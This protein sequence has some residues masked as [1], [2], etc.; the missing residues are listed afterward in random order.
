MI[1]KDNIYVLQISLIS[2]SFICYTFYQHNNLLNEE[3]EV[4]KEENEVLKEE[5]EVFKK[6]NELLK[7]ENK[8]LKEENNININK[9][10]NL[11][12]LF[13]DKDVW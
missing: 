10:N 1:F 9:M 7:E 12:S 8:L 2:I 3:N 11:Y 4:L 13:E 6:E 5:N